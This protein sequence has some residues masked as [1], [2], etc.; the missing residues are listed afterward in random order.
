[1]TASKLTK[2]FLALIASIIMVSGAGLYFGSEIL[3]QKALETDRKKT[4]AQILTDNIAKLKRLQ[5][6][7][8]DKAE[9]VER[10]N[11]IVSE[12]RQYQ[13]QDQVVRDVTA[14]ASRAGVSISGFNFTESATSIPQPG[15]PVIAGVKKLEAT[16]TLRTPIKYDNFLTFLKAIEQ[17]LTKMQVTGVNMSPDTKDSEAINNP[18]IGLQVYVRE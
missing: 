10:A 3:R 13:Y 8:N 6:E 7:L 18:S 12:S 9:I 17:N 2:I 1:M 11:Q 4:D 14:Y 15:D 5:T 16:V